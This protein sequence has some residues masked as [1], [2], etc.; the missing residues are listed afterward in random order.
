[1]EVGDAMGYWQIKILYDGQCPV[2]RKEADLL[3][4][5]DGN[6]QRLLLEDIADAQFVPSK[7][8]LTMDQGMSQIHGILPSGRAVTG[9]EVFRRAY[10]AVGLG[11]MLAPTNW[12]LLR[13][14]FNKAY[15]WFARNRLWL[16]ARSL[17][18]VA[19]RCG[20]SHKTA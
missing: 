14:V 2:C 17:G 15:S 13:G 19:G 5:L 4:W 7:Y 8:G 16:T 9:M 10:D 18:C 1:M 3:R 11:W 6:R 20:V 12:P